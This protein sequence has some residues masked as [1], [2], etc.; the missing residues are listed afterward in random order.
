M[1]LLID[2]GAYE[3]FGDLAMLEAAVVRLRQIPGVS[4][5]VQQ[6]PMAWEG[7]NVEELKYDIRPPG[8]ILRR[9]VRLSRLR[10]RLQTLFLDNAEH[11]RRMCHRAMATARLSSLYPIRV[12]GRPM[13]I[14]RFCKQFDALYIAGGGDLND[15]FPEALW[16]CCALIAAFTAQ[17]KP[18]YL[19]GQQIGPIHRRESDL[20]LQ[21]AL[22]SATYV[23]VREPTDSIGFCERA[24]IVGARYAM[25]GDDSFG[26]A[27]A[28]PAEVARLLTRHGV[29][30]GEFI[31][32]NVRIGGY[33]PVE[34]AALRRIG[35]LLCA[36]QTATGM[37]LL[38]VPISI[39]E[40]DSD[41]ESARLLA[42]HL[43]G[44]PLQVLEGEQ[45]SAA[46]LKG[47]LGAAY[48]AVGMSYH[49]GT[50]A[51]SGG[52]PAIALYTGDYYAQKARG[53]SRF[54]GDDRLAVS[55]DSLGQ[56]A[57]T[58]IL[59]LFADT[60]LRARLRKHADHAQQAWARAFD[61]NVMVPL[62]AAVKH[63]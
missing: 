34:S 47:V 45:F 17:G 1:K 5:H 49:F 40:S 58:N 9:F 52:V 22:R 56:Q 46:L 32:V 8:S 61:Q 54:W 57:A 42:R 12:A 53:V 35:E 63:Q 55:I 10:G 62:E 37:P 14:R 21:S 11:W 28:S 6:S 26:I 60:D 25:T 51:L 18:A 50:F 30:A 4:L 23:G 48:G 38:A 3:N 20:M 27:P 44:S 29:R 19:S 15:V 16:R 13:T 39:A 43:D 36:L 59:S 31:A 2:H 33:V 7:D 41:I 24:G